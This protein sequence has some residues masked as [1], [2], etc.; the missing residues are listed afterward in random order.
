MAD[1]KSSA[2]ELTQLIESAFFDQLSTHL[3]AAGELSTQIRKRQSVRLSQVQSLIQN[4]LDAMNVEYTL[5]AVAAFEVLAPVVGREEAIVV[6]DECL[7]QPLRPQILAA[8][9][10]MLDEAED[11]FTTIVEASKQR[12][13]HYFGSS[14]QFEH[15]IDDDYGYVLEI[16]RC[17]Y[18]ETLRACDALELQPSLCRADVN[19]IDAIDPTLHRLRFVRPSTFATADRCRMWF[20][21]T[22]GDDRTRLPVIHGT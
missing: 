17:L 18:H 16:K 12:E 7:H 8:T 5:L 2:V 14:F 9:R 1:A 21:R 20:M 19:W 6:L 4:E 22:D 11:P 10:Q 13:Q 3:P 15:P